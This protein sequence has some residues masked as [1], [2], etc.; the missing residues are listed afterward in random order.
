LADVDQVAVYHN[1]DAEALPESVVERITAG[2]IDWITIT[3][4][5]I[6]ARLHDLL[7]EPA[8]CRIGRDIRLASL[9]PV[10]TEAARSVGWSVAAEAALFTWEGLVQAVVQQVAR[11]RT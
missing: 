4:P 10:T 2:T 3:S 7:P 1:A 11:E 5:A 8:R 6:T 9:S